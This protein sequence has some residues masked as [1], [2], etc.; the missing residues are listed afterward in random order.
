VEYA[1]GSARARYDLGVARYADLGVEEARHLPG[2]F[3]DTLRFGRSPHDGGVMRHSEVD[4]SLILTRMGH[5]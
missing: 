1:L 5:L 3:N 4:R 2:D